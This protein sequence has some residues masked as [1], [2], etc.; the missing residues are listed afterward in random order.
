[1]ECRRHIYVDAALSVKGYIK[2]GAMFVRE[3]LTGTPMFS[4]TQEKMLNSLCYWVGTSHSDQTSL[5]HAGTHTQQPT[6]VLLHNK[7]HYNHD[8]DT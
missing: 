5:S 6:V 8:T 7:M 3:R 2:A 1:M 4:Y